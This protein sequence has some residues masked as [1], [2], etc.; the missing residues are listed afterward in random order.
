VFLGLGACAALP[1]KSR[2]VF[3]PG[4]FASLQADWDKADESIVDG[5]KVRVLNSGTQL[6]LLVSTDDRTLKDE[7]SG[8]YAQS[9][10]FWFQPKGG[11][12]RGLRVEFFARKGGDPWKDP[13]EAMDH[14]VYLEGPSPEGTPR[15]LSEEDGVECLE[16]VESGT[17]VWELKLPLRAMGKD[18]CV[19]AAPGDSLRLGIE[20]TPPAEADPSGGGGD[21]LDHKEGRHLRR[22]TDAVVLQHRVGDGYSCVLDVLL[23]PVPRG[24]K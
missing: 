6:H 20:A 24:Q 18:F 2:W 7:F 13:I 3:E 10:L 9:V 22:D 8:Q 23:A 17:L 5:L 15:S 4:D 12:G 16:R 14:R 1:Q 11:V 21:F 19:G